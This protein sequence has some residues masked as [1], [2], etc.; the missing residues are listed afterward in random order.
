M[1]CS[2]SNKEIHSE[3]EKI[4]DTKIL[5]S[6]RVSGGDIN[7]TYRL[8]LSQGT[9]FLKTNT[10]APKDLFQAE[11]KGLKWLSETKAIRV[12]KVLGVSSPQ[13]PIPFLILE[14]L[15]F[16]PPTEKFGIQ[17]GRALANQH[18]LTS[19][20]CGLD[21]NNYIG[22]L[23]QMNTP[24]PNWL[25]F[26]REYRLLPQITAA[27]RA[28]RINSKLE[29]DLK[30]LLNRLGDHIPT[31]PPLSRLHGDL[32]SGNYACISRDTPV[33]FDPAAYAGDREIDIAMM[34]LFGHIPSQTLAAYNQSWPLPKG[35]QERVKLYQLY[36]LLVHV[37]LFGD[38]YA[39]SVSESIRPYI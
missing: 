18:R 33:I 10:R 36:P 8:K 5:A 39:N 32:W 1:T 30:S 17:L 11:A 2:Q 19:A 28:N 16:T 26:Y 35:W 37:N 22:T 24:H 3:I 38:S 15:E 14:E 25:T 20:R 31:A 23:P 13:S 12:P 4:L 27:V 21:H 34:I 6:F 9:V 29:K 7:E